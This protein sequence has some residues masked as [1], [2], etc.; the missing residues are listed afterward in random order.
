MTTSAFGTWDIIRRRAACIW[1]E[2]IRLRISGSPS[3]WRCSSLDLLLRHPEVLLVVEPLVGV[4][5]RRK[6][7]ENE[8]A[9]AQDPERHPEKEERDCRRV[10]L[11][12]AGQLR[13][14]PRTE[15]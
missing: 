14:E 8:R 6:N 9:G 2:R 3:C 11:N 13:N 5:E 10:R 4:V 15:R 1:S 12:Q 7:N